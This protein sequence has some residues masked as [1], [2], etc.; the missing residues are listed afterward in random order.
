MQPKIKHVKRANQW[1]VTYFTGD[2]EKKQNQAWF[3]TEEEAQNYL[4]TVGGQN[5]K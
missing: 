3:S 1:C 4:L 2:K 5:A